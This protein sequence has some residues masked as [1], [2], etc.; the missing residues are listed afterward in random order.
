MSKI[1]LHITGL[2]TL[3]ALK[4]PRGSV[5]LDHFIPTAHFTHILPALKMLSIFL[6]GLSK[7]RKQSKRYAKL[8]WV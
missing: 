5:W 1:V 3:R 4:R 2:F 8:D 7:R 6:F